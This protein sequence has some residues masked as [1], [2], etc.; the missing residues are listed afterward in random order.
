MSASLVASAPARERLTQ[1]CQQLGLQISDAQQQALLDYAD[2]LL[3]WNATYNL[4]AIRQA[5]EVLTHHILDCLAVLPKLPQQMPLT[6]LDVGAG[7]GLPGVVWA[8]VC[9]HWQITCADAVGKKMAFVNQA[10]AQLRLRNLSGVHTR[11]DLKKPAPGL[12]AGGY[13]LI[14]SRA[15]ASLADFTALTMFH[16]KHAPAADLPGQW[17]ALKGKLPTEEIASLSS[18][19]AAVKTE[20][21]QVPGLDESRC[22]VWLRGS[23]HQA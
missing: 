12:R 7:G 16:V 21:I 23:A 8:I 20:D 5:D 3:K 17:L 10:A 15:F 11:L 19:I 9:S 6:I 4:T 14:T 2:L 22:L 18:S 1:G 13:D